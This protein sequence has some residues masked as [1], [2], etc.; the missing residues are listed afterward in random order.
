MPLALQILNLLLSDVDLGFGAVLQGS[1]VQE[2]A[3]ERV[4]LTP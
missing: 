4:G 2:L 3:E 1:Y